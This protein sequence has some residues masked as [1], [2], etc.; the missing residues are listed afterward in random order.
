MNLFEE[1]LKTNKTDFIALNWVTIADFAIW[2][3]TCTFF[4]HEHFWDAL[5]DTLK[6]FPLLKKHQERG[7]KELKTHY[8]K[9]QKFPVTHSQLTKLII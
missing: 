2:D 3:K 8:D 1:R 4:T 9:S 6:H 5:G 7:F